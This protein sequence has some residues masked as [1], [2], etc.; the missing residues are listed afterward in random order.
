M[1]LYLGTPQKSASIAKIETSVTVTMTPCDSPFL[2]KLLD[3]PFQ[4]EPE[5]PA[6]H[7]QASK[8]M[9]SAGL[10]AFARQLWQVVSPDTGLYI[11]RA[12]TVHI[13]KL[14]CLLPRGTDRVQGPSLGLQRGGSIRIKASPRLAVV[15]PLEDKS[16]G[17]NHG[18]CC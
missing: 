6:L 7:K 12:H 13:A 15:V 5:N 4:S 11:P 18:R 8:L 10:S 9:L 3:P 2:F 14:N 1:S 16:A 17:R